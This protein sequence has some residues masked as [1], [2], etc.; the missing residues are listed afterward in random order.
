MRCSKCGTTTPIGRNSAL[1]APRDD[2]R[3]ENPV[4][5]NR[6]MCVQILLVAL[7]PVVIVLIKGSRRK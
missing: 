6:L 5:P 7:S 4:D 3:N 1:R 2:S